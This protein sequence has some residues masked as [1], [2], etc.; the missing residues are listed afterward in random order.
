MHKI[1]P[2]QGLLRVLGVLQKYFGRPQTKNWQN[3]QK[4]LKISPWNVSS[5]SI[6][7]H[8]VVKF[9]ISPDPLFEL[10]PGPQISPD[11]QKKLNFLRRLYFFS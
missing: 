11:T 6:L 1:E 4:F 10:V 3:F 8:A 5:F 7:L 9:Q 2:K